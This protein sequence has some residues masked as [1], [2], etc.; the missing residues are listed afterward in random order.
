MA[1]N[2]SE[3]ASLVKEATTLV[4]TDP[5]KAETL[6]HK[7]LSAGPGSTEATSRDYEA[8]L[9]ALGELYRDQKRPNELGELLKT[10]RSSFS[11][12]AKAKSAKLGVYL[13]PWAH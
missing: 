13:L 5:S 7:I 12:F 8:A 4:K 6:F 10:S 3:T 2:N 1:P 11:S 9:V